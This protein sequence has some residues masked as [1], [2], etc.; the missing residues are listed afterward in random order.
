[1][2]GRILDTDILLLW[3]QDEKKYIGTTW[4]SGGVVVNRCILHRH[5]SVTVCL[6]DQHDMDKR[7]C[8]RRRTWTN[9]EQSESLWGFIKSS[10]I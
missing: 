6:K 2:H 1:M 5:C 7:G 8:R 4:K 9:N 10:P 3:Q